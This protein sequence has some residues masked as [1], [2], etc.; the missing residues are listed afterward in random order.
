MVVDLGNK[1]LWFW[2]EKIACKIGA[3]KRNQELACLWFL[4]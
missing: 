1:S 4:L 3:S 2:A